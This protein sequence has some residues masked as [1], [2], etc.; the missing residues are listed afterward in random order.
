MTS[1]PSYIHVKYQGEWAVF[2]I[3]D[4]N[5][6]EGELKTDKE[7]LVQA[8]ILIHKEDLLANWELAIT[9]QPV[10]KVEPLK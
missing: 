2:S 6:I 5:I 1:L 4:G 10:F 8:W 3:S 7:K 9:G